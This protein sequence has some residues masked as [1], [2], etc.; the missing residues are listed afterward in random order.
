MAAA[1][2]PAYF[3]LLEWDRGRVR[4]IREFRYVPY[5]AREAEIDPA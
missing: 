5:V 1:A 4:A 3:T 2:E